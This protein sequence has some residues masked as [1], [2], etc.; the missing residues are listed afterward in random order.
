MLTWARARSEG[1][2][3]ERLVRPPRLHRKAQENIEGDLLGDVSTSLLP[4]RGVPKVPDLLPIVMSK[5]R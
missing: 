2:Q 5:K 1:Y 4:E 3:F